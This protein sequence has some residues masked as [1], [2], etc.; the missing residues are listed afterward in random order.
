M[1]HPT[2]GAGAASP[3]IA[4][5][6]LPPSYSGKFDDVTEGISLALA[7][8]VSR[9]AGRLFK[10]DAP[11]LWDTY[12]AS[13]VDRDERQYHNCRCCRTFIERYG[14]LVTVDQHGGLRSA[15]WNEQA[16]GYSHPYFNVVKALREH[17]ED[18]RVVDVFLTADRRWGTYEQGGFTHLW[19]Q[20]PAGFDLHRDRTLT[21]EQV[22][23]A[24]RQDRETLERAV[25]TMPVEHLKRARSLVTSGRLERG[26]KFTGQLDFLIEL[27]DM[28]AKPRGEARSRIL[29][30]AVG[31]AAAGWCSPR[32]SIVGALVE[33]LSAQ[34]NIDTAIQRHNERVSPLKYQR[35]TKLSEG[36]IKQAEKVFEQLGLAASLRR[37]FAT[38]DDLQERLWVPKTKDQ[39]KRGTFGHLLVKN[40]T[41]ASIVR[42]PETVTWAKFQRDILPEAAS[43]EVMVPAIGDFCAFTT[44]ADPD[45]PPIIRWDQNGARNPV[46]WYVY[47]AGSTAV[48]WNLNSGYYAE[49]E[50]VTAMPCMW[51]EGRQ[52]P[53]TRELGNSVLLVVKGCH[54]KSNKS[55][56][57]FP[58][59]LRGDLHSVR[60]T[61]EAHSR[62]GKLENPPE[63]SRH[64]SGLRI[65]GSHGAELRVL[66]DGGIQVRYKVDRW[67]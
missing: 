16:L 47:H 49:V 36:N 55:L 39:V 65:A 67:E 56:A 12:L 37:R 54:D 53:D 31:R 21:A 57:L 23:A 14:S 10:V 44:A 25:R 48:Q 42:K 60:S 11:D 46:G 4:Q 58:E 24:K 22:M 13:F 41:E 17:A 63:G 20:A 18:K 38:V 59:L 35:P 66:F 34:M 30:E 3:H 51:G 26:D 64:A 1:Q 15:V 52:R 40:R 19:A 27:K 7:A 61:I 43:L 50:T 29:W 6:V 33:D 32:A 28:L 5:K 62:S 8:S 9:F 45:A 2:L